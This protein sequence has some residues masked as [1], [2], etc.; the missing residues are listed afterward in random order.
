MTSRDT[1]GK[2]STSDL[3][4]SVNDLSDD[5]IFEIYRRAHLF[6]KIFNE[7][8]DIKEC[9]SWKEKRRKVVALIFFESSTRTQL[10]FQLASTHL[11]IRFIS[12]NSKKD[13]SIAKGETYLE[14][15]ANV[16][17]MR[18]DLVVLRTSSAQV[19]E[20]LNKN[21]KKDIKVINAGSGVSEHPTQ[22]LLDAFTILEKRGAQSLKG[23][24]ILIVGDVLHSRV[25]NS[26][27]DLMKRLGA[28]VSICAPEGMIPV[29][30]R[31]DGVKNF[32]DLKSGMKW[33]TVCMG[34][35]VQL[36][37]HTQISLGVS[38][39]EY[40]NLFGLNEERIQHLS[41]KGLILHPGPFVPELDF[42]E[43][44]LDDPRCCVRDQVTNGVFVRTALLSFVLGA[45]T[46]E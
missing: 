19:F 38:R 27:L 41:K 10:S 22:A 26:N 12:I 34:L 28:S 43:T 33:C 30:S 25:A 39:A 18:P 17:A 40:R 5:Q 45:D 32:K 7:G 6:K 16:I 36:E 20:A 37:R 9:L 14:T 42:S 44:L 2:M 31:W 4:F 11:G 29:E 21:F 35:R 1:L 8:E 13:S 15:V 3:L 46:K 23:E 24:K